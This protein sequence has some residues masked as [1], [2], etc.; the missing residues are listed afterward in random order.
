MGRSHVWGKVAGGA[1]L[2]VTVAAVSGCGG[3]AEADAPKKETAAAAPSLSK[4]T[5]AFQGAVSDLDSMDC[6][7]EAGTCYE[8]MTAVMGPARTL[9]K[10]MHAAKGTT[11]GFWSPAY[12][13]IDK[14]EEGYAVGDDQGGGLN[15]TTSNRIAVFGG[16][17]DL[18]DWMDE[19]PVE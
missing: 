3:D 16:A 19:H 17:H 2:A 4:A 7:E 14:M 6:P 15:N 5:T 8:E 9:R 18:S 10:A 11:A 1:L 12:A 13:L